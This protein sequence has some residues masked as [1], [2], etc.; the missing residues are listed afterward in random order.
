MLKI[1]FKVLF[2]VLTL[3]PVIAQAGAEDTYACEKDKYV[4][5]NQTNGSI[6][7]E[8]DGNPWGEEFDN[9]F[10]SFEIDREFMRNNYGDTYETEDYIYGTGARENSELMLSASYSYRFN[11]NKGTF[12]AIVEVEGKNEFWLEAYTWKCSAVSA[13]SSSSSSTSQSSL[14]KCNITGGKEAGLT[15]AQMDAFYYDVLD[16]VKRLGW[17]NAVGLK[18][19][20]G[21]NMKFPKLP[22]RTTDDEFIT[23]HTSK[24]WIKYKE[25]AFDPTPLCYDMRTKQQYRLKSKNADCR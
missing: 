17:S 18:E 9:F 13:Q 7:S 23:I 19:C 1:K 8:T 24:K 25:D 2:I 15:Q 3:V 11:T 6:C 16:S 22:M 20:D 14:P 12:S 10:G 5:I 21:G 4:C